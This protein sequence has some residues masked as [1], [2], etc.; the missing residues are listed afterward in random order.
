VEPQGRP[1]PTKYCE[2]SDI[3][4]CLFS[5]RDGEC[6]F[7][8]SPLIFVRVLSY[9]VP[10][11]S[12]TSCSFCVIYQISCIFLITFQVIPSVFYLSIDI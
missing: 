10:K 7:C 1:P 9:N 3:L 12:T 4:D 11:F 6:N 8:A 5:S 2:P